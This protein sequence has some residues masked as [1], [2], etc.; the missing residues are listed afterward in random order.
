M[1]IRV[2]TY[3]DAFDFIGVR[4]NDNIKKILLRLSGEGR[5]ERSIAYSIWREHETIMKFRGD[6]RF[7]SV[8]ENSIRKWSWSRDDPRWKE[9]NEKKEQEEK[10]KQYK[11][12]DEALDKL[13]AELNKNAISAMKVAQV[14]KKA[15]RAG[16]PGFIYFIQG[17]S[18]GAVKIGYTKDVF[19]RL[20]ALQTGYPDT[21]IIRCCIPGSP[22][23]ESGYHEMF[24]EERLKGEWF[25]PSERLMKKI[26]A[27]IEC[28]K[29]E[30]DA[31]IN[32]AVSKAD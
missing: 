12:K 30:D 19:S 6:S 16:Y 3:Q 7:Y 10:A 21:L 4:I 25:T 1:P 17:K 32:L 27:L 20:K 5:S 13:T 11:S 14:T 29:R 26:D 9:H 24:K 15:P 23:T 2:I 8:L 28:V 18:G 22:D 31:L